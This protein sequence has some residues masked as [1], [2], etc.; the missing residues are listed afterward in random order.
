M[1]AVWAYAAR[2]TPSFTFF[3]TAHGLLWN[4]LRPVFAD[5]DPSSFQICPASVERVMTPR[6]SAILGVHMFG[7][8]APVDELERM[9]ARAGVALIFDGAHALGTRFG[10]KSAAASGDATVYSL[11]PTKQLTCGEG[12]LIVTRHRKLADMLRRARN[13]GKGAEYDCDILGLNARMSELQ[14]ALGRADL[15][16]L[17]EKIRR[18]NEIAAIYES[19]LKGL[20]G[21][22]LQRTPQGSVHSRKDFGFVLGQ[23]LNRDELAASLAAQGVD[24]RSYFYPP[25]HRQ[26][27]YSRFYRPKVEAL[28]ATDAVSRNILCLP[29]HTR[30]TD[31]DA[32]R[33]ADA[34]AEFATSRPMHIDEP[35]LVAM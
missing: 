16:R 7:A 3:A 32:V 20:P 35:A 6:T 5:C 31:A 28:R 4:N 14:A 15:P 34:V 1:S 23:G 19:R 21:L 25:L 8:P 33:I 27:L 11:S 17:P 12:G 10:G 18:R 30:V 24:T 22:R 26:K 13:Y 29:I 9:A 2:L